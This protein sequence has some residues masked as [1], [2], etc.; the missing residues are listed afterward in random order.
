VEK[1]STGLDESGLIELLSN[2][3][4][5]LER[6]PTLPIFIEDLMP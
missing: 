5:K 6:L 3:S 1:R 2:K 4:L